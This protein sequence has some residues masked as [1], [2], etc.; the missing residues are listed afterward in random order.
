MCRERGKNIIFRMG[1]GGI[2]IRSS[3]ILREIYFQIAMDTL[4]QQI[5]RLIC[6]VV[7]VEPMTICWYVDITV[8]GR[9]KENIAVNFI[10]LRKV[11]KD[12]L[13]IL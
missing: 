6:G 4:Q 9:L 12:Y 1:G 13:L 10:S 8:A 2:N 5:F 3:R 11:K 7:S